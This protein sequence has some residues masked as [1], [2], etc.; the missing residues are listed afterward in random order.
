VFVVNQ[1]LFDL[2]HCKKLNAREP[3]ETDREFE[4]KKT[5]AMLVNSRGRKQAKE[6]E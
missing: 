4:V 6:K 1:R 5:D 2:T 3:K